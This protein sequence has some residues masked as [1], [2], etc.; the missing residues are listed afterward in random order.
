MRTCVACVIP[1]MKARF[2][3]HQ[4]HFNA[5]KYLGNLALALA[6]A[7]EDTHTLALTLALVCVSVCVLT[8]GWRG[9]VECG[10]LGTTYTPG[11]PVEPLNAGTVE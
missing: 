1:G 5:Q 6:L 4:R 7:L 2:M 9:E 8:H 10:F 11:V 3:L